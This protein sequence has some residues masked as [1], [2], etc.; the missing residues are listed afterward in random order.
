MTF[1]ILCY[2]MSL[3]IEFLIEK[4][5]YVINQNVTKVNKTMVLLMMY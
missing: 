2:K 1:Q 4:V 5:K 3:K